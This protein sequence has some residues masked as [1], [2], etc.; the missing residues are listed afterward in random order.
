MGLDVERLKMDELR[1]SMLIEVEKATSILRQASRTPP[2]VGL[3]LGSGL[4]GLA[5]SIERSEAIPY[6]QIPHFPTTHATGHAGLWISGQLGGIPV[7]AMSGRAHLYEGHDVDRA[8]FPV[9]C[10]HALGTEILIASNA[11]GG[12]NPRFRQGQL[13]AIDSHIN[14]FFRPL[15]APSLL[16]EPHPVP[17]QR[18]IPFYD[19]SILQQWDAIATS[20]RWSLHRGTYLGTL[21]PTYETR[22][23]YRAFRTMGADMVGMSTLPEV[24]AARRLGMRVGAISVITN[25]ATPDRLAKT[26]HQEVVD[27]AKLAEARLLPLIRSWLSELAGPPD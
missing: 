13:V 10:M 2:K 3:I 17:P 12:L 16:G 15:A 9:R 27:V 8:T 5:A 6:E 4:G 11:A 19:P 7:V 21:G 23:E 26:A 18:H 25:I 1:R 22:S 24:E 14:L 20:H